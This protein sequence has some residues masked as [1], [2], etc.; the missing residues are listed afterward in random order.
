MTPQEL[1]NKLDEII[2]HSRTAVLATTDANKQSHMRWM[3]PAMLKFR[4]RE[5]FAFSIPGSAKLDHIHTNHNVQWMFQS[6]DLRE[7]I[8][9]EAS[10]NIID[11]P[12]IKTELMEIIGHRLG[13]FWKANVGAEEFVVLET[14]IKHATYFLPMKGIRQ[15]VNFA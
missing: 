5:I 14:A 3:T 2:D 10:A 8:T 4:P 7:I 1:T 6:R 9:V 12:S 11:N 15:N 13:I